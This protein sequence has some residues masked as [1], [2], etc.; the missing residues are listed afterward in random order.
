QRAIGSCRREDRRNARVHRHHERR[1][2]ARVRHP[3]SAVMTRIHGVVVCAIATIATAPLAAQDPPMA[4]PTLPVVLTRVGDYVKRFETDLSN[5][6]AEE[7]YTQEV[8]RGIALGAV[9]ELKSDLLLVRPS[10]GEAYLQFRDV[11]E[12]DGRPIR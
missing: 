6:V 2:R 3:S 11:F 5:I 9:R 8:R 10:P 12:V 4:E 1:G 7:H